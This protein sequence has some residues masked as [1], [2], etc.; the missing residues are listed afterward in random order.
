MHDFC[1]E[2]AEWVR[3]QLVLWNGT[4]SANAV[5]RVMRALG[6]PT[7]RVDALEQIRTW[8][9]RG[10][11]APG[12]SPQIALLE[13][14]SGTDLNSVPNRRGNRSQFGSGAPSGTDLIQFPGA[15]GTDLPPKSRRD[16]NGSLIT[17]TTVADILLTP[18]GGSEKTNAGARE[19]ALKTLARAPWIAALADKFR[20]LGRKRLN[21]LDRDQRLVLARGFAAVC[22][23]YRISESGNVNK[24]Q[25]LVGTFAR[26]CRVKRFEDLTV[27][28]F[29]AYGLRA[30][31]LRGGK[32]FHSPYD[33][34]A[35]INYEAAP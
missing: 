1:K 29:V 30:L 22:A 27:R 13:P 2:D 26:F 8:L 17:A 12:P 11:K 31:K 23:G 24:A 34:E 20:P 10:T 28:Q 18:F 14:P 3:D 19:E 9:G 15:S 21:D 32:P 35:G 5:Y 33:V 4:W 16:L 7:R 25:Q 6:V